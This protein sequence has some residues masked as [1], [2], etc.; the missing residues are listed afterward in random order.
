MLHGWR[1][2]RHF[3]K[4]SRQVVGSPFFVPPTPIAFSVALEALFRDGAHSPPT[5]VHSWLRFS[6]Y[7]PCI[8]AAF[9]VRRKV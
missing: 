7:A 6:G 8:G 9:R 5:H 2:D 1:V 3:P 4:G